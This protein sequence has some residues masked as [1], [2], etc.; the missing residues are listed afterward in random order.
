MADQKMI[1]DILKDI[2][3]G[4]K[5]GALYV[6]MVQA[7][8]DMLKIYFEDGKIYAVRYGSAVGNDCLD[9]LEYYNMYSATFFDGIP[10]P[11][12][13]LSD[14]PPHETI[15]RKFEELKKTV[16]LR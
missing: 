1:S 5:S 7:S 11:K 14:L 16:K 12:A 13:A 4:K 9:I 10:A 6:D 2:N 8:E 3:A 15:L